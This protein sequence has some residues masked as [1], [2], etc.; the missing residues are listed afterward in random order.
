MK[1]AS[2]IRMDPVKAFI[3]IA[4]SPA[5][6]KAYFIVSSLKFYFGEEKTLKLGILKD[7]N[8]YNNSSCYI[9]NLVYTYIFFFFPS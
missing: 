7:F 8:E 2:N 1:H 6:L 4:W 5:S 3:E 9:S